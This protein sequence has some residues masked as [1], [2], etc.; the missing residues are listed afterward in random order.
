MSKIIKIAVFYEVHKIKK[1]ICLIIDIDYD[2]T[3]LNNFNC[4]GMTV[5]AMHFTVLFSAVKTGGT[6][7]QKSCLEIGEQKEYSLLI[8]LILHLFVYLFYVKQL[9]SQSSWK[10]KVKTWQ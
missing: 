10:L 2:K 1:V 8:I 9:P 4:S 3:S 7:V 5:S 6:N